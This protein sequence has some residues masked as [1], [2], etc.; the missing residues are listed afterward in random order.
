MANHLFAHNLVDAFAEL[1]HAAF[2][3]VVFD[4]IF[5]CRRCE[6]QREVDRKIFHRLGN[7][8]AAHDFLFLFGEIPV[9]MNH[10]HAVEQRT[11]H[12]IQRI[13]RG[14]EKDLAQIVIEVEVIVVERVVLFRIEELEQRT[15]G[16]SVVSL[17][18][19]L[20]DLVEHEE[21]VVAFRLNDAL[22]DA[23]AHGGDVSSAVSA[24]FALVMQ[25]AERDT[26]I[27]ASQTFGDAAAQ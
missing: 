8:V 11:G 22:H 2:P 17:S 3:S 19:N 10:F 9:D 27:F 16:I 26:H 20:V 15:L 21:R 23:S 4:E 18:R 12:G 7:Q 1:A 14:N 6:L 13:G 24:N 5:A 25:T